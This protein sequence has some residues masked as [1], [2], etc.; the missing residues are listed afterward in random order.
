MQ[1]SI[2]QAKSPNRTV[3]TSFTPH[4]PEDGVSAFEEG[5]WVLCLA[6]STS[7]LF[8]TTAAPS[9]SC[10]LSNG[11]VQVY[12]Q[13]SLLPVT[14]FLPMGDASAVTD[15]IY[16]PQ[17]TLL[18]TGQDGSIVL[19]DL[20]QPTTAALR[21]TL[22]ARG[23]A[24]ESAL[25]ISLGFD[26]YLA[27]VAC[28]RAR[29]YFLDLRT[30]QVVGCYRDSHTD[31][32]TQVTF[33]PE[34]RSLLATAG[35]DGLVCVFDTTKQ[36]EEMA[37][38]SAINVGS[39]CRRMGFCGDTKA[40]YCL[41]GSETASLWNYETATC[42]HDFEGWRLR[43]GLSLLS[44]N[45]V[46]IDYLVDARWDAQ[47]GELQLCAGNSAGNAAIFRSLLGTQSAQSGPELQCSPWQ[48][49]DLLVGGH[50]CVV[51]AWCPLNLDAASTSLG[52]I[53]AGEDA[54]LCEWNVLHRSNNS[55]DS[56]MVT[57]ST[58]TSTTNG[59]DASVHDGSGKH[60]ADQRGFGGGP[61]RRQRHRPSKQ[62]I[63]PY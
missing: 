49:S 46:E 20:R 37:L 4:K 7:S 1:C 26:G 2:H 62:T 41:T 5:D 6:S 63:A 16:G 31:A 60:N 32:V 35:E 38:G 54:R 44:N 28:D 30:S 33:H 29:V 48:V 27:A 23:A 43:E 39:S 13:Q 50:R 14:S 9:V 36:S 47:R 40:I 55:S 21:A 42:I 19:A 3:V 24:V 56:A 58:A 10:A 61:I 22:P 15:L 57:T 17:D 25:A 51:R 52:I 34:K 11:Q 45:T 12:D 8:P 59:T 53:T 18:V